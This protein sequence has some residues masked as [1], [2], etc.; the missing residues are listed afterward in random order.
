MRLSIRLRGFTQEARLLRMLFE[1]RIRQRIIEAAPD[2]L[3]EKIKRVE[4]KRD[5][6]KPKPARNVVNDRIR[7][8][9]HEKRDKDD[10]GSKGN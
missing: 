2:A 10:K 8:S 9:K 4:S 1:T 7:D 5:P 6:S 3:I